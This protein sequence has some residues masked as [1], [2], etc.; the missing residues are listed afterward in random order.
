LSCNFSS[1]EIFCLKITHNF[2][3]MYTPLQTP[4]KV[5]IHGISFIA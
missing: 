1:T 2:R 5:Y 3:G 4:S